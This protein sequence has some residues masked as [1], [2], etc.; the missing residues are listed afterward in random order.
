MPPKKASPKVTKT[1]KCVL[2]PGKVCEKDHTKTELLQLAK[3][4]GLKQVKSSMTKKEICS[5]LNK[6]LNELKKD[7]VKVPKKLAKELSKEDIY[8]EE[9]VYDSDKGGY[10]RICK[11]GKCRKVDI[12]ANEFDLLDAFQPG[13]PLMVPG[14]AMSPRMSAHSR[15]LPRVL[16]YAHQL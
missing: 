10:K 14:L 12:K 16:F 9:L 5:A 3:D 8:S 11:D 7:L 1:T 2:L 4:C 13:P 15:L 6:V